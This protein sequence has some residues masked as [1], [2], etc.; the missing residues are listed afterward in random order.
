MTC[1]DRLEVMDA[2]L[3]GLQAGRV[4][5]GAVFLSLLVV[6]GVGLRKT[7]RLLAVHEAEATLEADFKRLERG[8]SGWEG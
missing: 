8:S 2:M 6:L 1:F 5:A 4:V 7:R 3:S